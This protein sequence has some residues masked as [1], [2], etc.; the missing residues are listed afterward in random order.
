MKAWARE[1]EIVT[2]ITWEIKLGWMS[3]SNGSETHYDQRGS[4]GTDKK[5]LIDA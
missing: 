4:V 1:S 2:V 3:V 5:K